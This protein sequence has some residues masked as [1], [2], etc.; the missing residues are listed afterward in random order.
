FPCNVGSVLPGAANAKTILATYTVP[1]GVTDPIVDT[2]TV[3]SGT[4]D[5]VPENTASARVSV[6]APIAN[7]SI[8]KDDGKNTVTAGTQITYQMTVTNSGPDDAV[9][10]VAITDVVPDS[11]TNVTWDCATCTP[12]SG[13]GSIN[14][15]VSLPKGA[16][17]AFSLTGTVKPDA[18]GTLV[19]T[20]NAKTPPPFAGSSD[21]SATDVDTITSEADL[22]ITKTGPATVI[23]GNN[24]V[25]TITVPH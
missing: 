13:T 4:P 19:N 10:L 1:L 16:S 20:V 11:L 2:M 6:L 21:V 7:L 22:S 14:T 15:T 18:I 23:P 25:Y 8:T 12:P 17:A 3:T 5:P 9:P 24:V